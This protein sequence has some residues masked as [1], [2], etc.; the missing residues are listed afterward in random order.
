[1]KFL[2]EIYKK[3]QNQLLCQYPNPV[4]WQYIIPMQVWH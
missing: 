4:N 2:D 3:L 1:M